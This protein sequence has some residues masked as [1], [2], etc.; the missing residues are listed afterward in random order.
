MKIDYVFPYVDPSDKE[1]QKTWE[2]MCLKHG[3]KIDKNSNRYRDYGTLKFLFRCLANNMP[4]INKVHMIVERE[5]QIPSWLNTDSVDVVF[6]DQII[7]KHNLPT[8]NSNT[9]EMYIH[10]IP[11]LTEHFIYGNDDMYP[12]NS[13]TPG[14]WFTSDG[15]PK[16]FIKHIKYTPKDVMYRQMLKHT[17]DFCRND[18]NLPCRNNQI[19]FSDHNINAMLKSVWINLYK[20]HK[21]EISDSCSTFRSAKNITQELSNFYLYLSNNFCRHERLNKYSNYKN[22]SPENIMG[23][24]LSNYHNICINDNGCEDTQTMKNAMI[25]AF[26]KKFPHKCKYEN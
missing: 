24:I 15:T 18:L 26:T 4:W 13:T 10:R 2:Q 19:L 23:L 22:K 14:D 17:E 5:S 25:H 8:Y 3:K 16:I 11:G 6:H 7:D 1:W 9:I 20:K 12:I 21:N